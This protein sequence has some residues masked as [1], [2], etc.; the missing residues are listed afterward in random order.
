MFE[1][2]Y[3]LEMCGVEIKIIVSSK[4]KRRWLGIDMFVLLG[5]CKLVNEN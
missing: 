3:H 5:H 2:H 1:F 4:E